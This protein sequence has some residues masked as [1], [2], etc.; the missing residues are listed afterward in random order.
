[1]NNT[2]EKT[3]QDSLVMTRKL[4]M[5][6]QINPNGTLFG[7][8]LLSWIDQAAYMS[9]QMHSGRPFVVT[10][11]MDQIVFHKPIFM[12]DH[13]VLKS[14]IT[15]VGRTSME[16]FVVVDREDGCNGFKE[17]ATHAWVT[18]VALDHAKKPT[19]VPSLKF[20]NESEEKMFLESKT[21]SRIK[22]KVNKWNAT[23]ETFKSMIGFKE[24]V[25]KE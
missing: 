3:P 19:R 1:M 23:T 2:I 4:V 18:F 25:K 6:D 16:I 7:G 15:S 13:V 5:P 10:V 9:A 21:R 11:S 24:F 20:K 12:G 14:Q 22:Q 17:Y 8:V